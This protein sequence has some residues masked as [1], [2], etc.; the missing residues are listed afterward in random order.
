MTLP[1][2]I[3]QQAQRLPDALQHELLDFI[4][5]LER[6]AEQ[7]E[8][9]QWSQFSLQAALNGLEEESQYSVADLKVRFQ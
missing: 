9:H 4:F 6:K 8:N 2:Q 1:Q 3:Y 7:E 5:Q